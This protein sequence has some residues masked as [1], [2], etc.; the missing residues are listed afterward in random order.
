MHRDHHAKL[1]FPFQTIASEYR[2]I[3]SFMHPIIIPYDEVAEVLVES[4]RYAES[5]GGIARQLQPYL[6]QVPEQALAALKMA[7][8]TEFIQPE[9]FAEQ[10]ILL[11]NKDLYSEE[12]GMNWDDPFF[13]DPEKLISA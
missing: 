13:I 5:V 7:G 9:K 11:V 4:L 10:F 12:A 3:E 1:S 2:L 6:V 8:A